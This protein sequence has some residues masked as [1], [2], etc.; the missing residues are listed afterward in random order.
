MPAPS[1]VRR[2]FRR[3]ARAAGWRPG[4]EVLEAR[5]APAAALRFVPPAGSSGAT[6]A[7]D[8]YAF[9]FRDLAAAGSAT[10][11]AGARDVSFDALTVAA[12]YSADSP[13]VFDQLARG[14]IYPSAVLTD[15]DAAGRTVAAW[16]LGDVTVVAHTVA[17]AGDR[18]VEEIKVGFRSVTAATGTRTASWDVARGTPTGPALPPGLTLA[19]PAPAARPLT[20][21]LSG[22]TA[23]AVT[24]PVAEARFGYANQ[25]TTGS[26]TEFDAV[27]LTADYTAASPALLS[28]LASGYYSAA[29]L[30]ET[31]ATGRPTARWT[32]GTAFLTSLTAAAGEEGAPTQELTL[33]YQEVAQ[34]YEQRVSAW[35]QVKNRDP[36]L[37]GIP[38][39]PPPRTP[40]PPAAPTGLTL[41][42]A[43]GSAPAA[44]LYPSG[45]SF[46]ANYNLAGVQTGR[47]AFDSLE[48]TGALSAGSHDVFAAIT[49]KKAYA[50]ATLTQYD[51]AGN[52]VAVWVLGTV[53]VTEQRVALGDG[54]AGEVLRLRFSA[55]TEATRTRTESWDLP[56]ASTAGPALPAGVTLAPLPVAPSGTTLQL[57]GATG[58]VTL[59]LADFHF[60]FTNTAEDTLLNPGAG[61]IESAFDTLDATAPLG[62]ESPAVFA[63]L[64]RGR[65]YTTATLTRTNAA[66]GVEEV[67]VLGGVFVTAV[68]VAGDTAGDG[69]TERFRFTFASATAAT[70]A[71][72]ASWDQARATPTGPAVPIGVTL[73]APTVP[74]SGITLKLSGGTATPV[75]LQLADARFGYE[76]LSSV[77]PDT[78]FDALTAV[79][80]AGLTTPALFAAVAGG[81]YYDTATLTRA[82]ATARPVEVWTFRKVFATGLEVTGE[83]GAAEQRVTFVF[84]KV[85]QDFDGRETGWDLVQNTDPGGPSVTR[86]TEASPPGRLTLDLAGGG[87]PA[88]S[89]SLDAFTFTARNGPP[90]AAA[91]VPRTAFDALRVTAPLSA[92]SHDVFVAL[93]SGKAYATAT[94]TQRDAAGNPV[95]VWVLGHVFVTGQALLVDPGAGTI[96]GLT[97]DF[98]SLT[99]V[100]SARRASWDVPTASENG[101]A[102]P[103]P[104]SLAPLEDVAPTVAGD[105]AAVTAAEGTPVTFTGRFGDANGNVTVA[106]TAS[107]GAVTK[108]DA[109]GT[110]AWTYTPPDGP[111]APTT[112]TIT[113]TDATG[114]RA[115]TT[116]TLTVENVLPRIDAVTAS[117][118]NEGGPVTLTADVFDPAGDRDPLTYIWVIISPKP[119]NGTQ[120]LA[121]SGRSV[122]FSPEAGG[123]LTYTLSVD[124]GDDRAV[125]QAG[126]FQVNARPVGVL[127]TGAT[128]AENRPIGTV[129]G[130]AGADDP[131]D[132]GTFAYALV[133]GAGDADNAA[134]TLDAQGV[135]RTATAFDFEARSTY[136]VRVRATD[137]GG[138]SVE[139]ALTVTVANANEAP[140]ITSAGGATATV[141]LDEGA[142]AVATVAATD[143]DAETRL[144]YSLAGDD[145]ALF[146]ID[147]DT[148]VLAF[149]SAPAFDA[150]SDRDGDNVY[151]V[152]VRASDGALTA[153]QE[154]RVIVRDVP[155]GDQPLL[156][157][158]SVVAVGG[159]DGVRLLNPD[160][161][162]GGSVM[163]SGGGEPARTATADFN[164]DGV[165]DVAVG[166]GTGAT[167]QVRVLDGKTGAELY[168]LQPFEL[169]YTGGVF[170]AAGDLDG[171]GV[172][173]LAVTPDVGGGPR[174]DVYSGAGMTLVASFFGLDDPDFRGGVR[175]AVGD[176][177]GDGVGDLVIGA[178]AGGAPRVVGYDGRALAAGARVRLFDDF[179]AFDPTLRGGVFV[180]VGD[181]TGDGRADVIVGAGGGGAPR[182]LALDGAALLGGR[183]GVLADFYAAPPTSRSG[184]RVAV[185]NLDA[186]TRAD[187]V[188]AAGDGDDARVVGY[189]ASYLTTASPPPEEFSIPTLPGVF[190]G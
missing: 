47:A 173:D 136:S 33:V 143:P 26:P 20:L 93:T 41:E 114:L 54:E 24:L 61:A 39:L 46:T 186:D 30:V 19:D 106:L 8:S 182:V 107:L 104:N 130:T 43:G 14:R 2:L 6:V 115:E 28:A 34:Q 190:V 140:R 129:V 152:R 109:A 22:G 113:A 96:E 94:L 50:T 82:G 118:L 160:G 122:T 171:D 103:S 70:A 12:S 86:P 89:L 153:E 32:F 7:L 40:A 159:P 101:P 55:L 126:A 189:R 73:V 91:P 154:L 80:A 146:T 137:A 132:T 62:A 84:Q 75:T 141:A 108:D 31:D 183:Y 38:P 100:T 145:A 169:T 18:P 51:A 37:G 157:G 83:P 52:K 147:P 16:V 95:A 44:T 131:G 166:S 56:S 60:E 87:A 119:G 3:P 123:L 53:L 45:F 188:V 177:N 102:G 77:A 48:V 64:V 21:Q 175:A 111:A 35:D 29:T 66:G 65:Q 76:L 184:A 74:T 88:A 110:W 67:W 57:A 63:A 180:A 124:D 92:A 133:P 172:P 144:V 112:V 142:T 97:L 116:F 72:T 179:Y 36:G 176:L 9:G 181:L 98:S 117:P 134:F 139:Q 78:A 165:V 138:L 156:V 68:T 174:V 1:W 11:G 4:V 187:L 121:L 162:S 151:V 58:T 23:P 185:K 10:P 135:L 170:V 15:T 149:R 168:R 127:L 178:G 13:L 161:S 128:V 158:V 90:T 99:A 69:V 120:R 163:P 155:A 79:A 81:R 164:R 17:G 150:P 105:A 85:G 25:Q 71:H 148:G 125:Q 27:T 42:L 49:G 167:A 59:P 5:L